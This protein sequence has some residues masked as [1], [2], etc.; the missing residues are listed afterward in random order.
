MGERVT[1]HASPN[2]DHPVL[3]IGRE[4]PDVALQ[5]QG[6]PDPDGMP[7]HGRDDGLAYLPR[8]R[9]GRRPR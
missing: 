9:R 6:E 4:D 1:H 3:R 2:L 8:R 7:V 5:R